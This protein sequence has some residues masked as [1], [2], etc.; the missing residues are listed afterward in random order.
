MNGIEEFAD[1][2]NTVFLVPRSVS[3]L[4]GHMKPSP[5]GRRQV[6]KEGAR[7]RRGHRRRQH[8]IARALGRRP[9]AR[10][11]GQRRAPPRGA[12]TAARATRAC[13]FNKL[14]P[15]GAREVEVEEEVEV[16]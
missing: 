3:S 8:G 11:K 14:R 10:A 5:R 1:T 16:V 2:P 4:R 12:R 7:G 15:Q 6:L 9:A 13:A